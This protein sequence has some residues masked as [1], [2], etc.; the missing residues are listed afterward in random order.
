MTAIEV[1]HLDKGNNDL[2]AFIFKVQLV[3]F[4]FYTKIRKASKY[5]NRSCVH[6]G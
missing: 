2:T 3:T 1:T 6:L 4:L 5:T